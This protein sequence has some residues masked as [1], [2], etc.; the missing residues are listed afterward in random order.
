M[1]DLRGYLHRMRAFR[2]APAMPNLTSYLSSLSSHGVRSRAPRKLRKRHVRGE[3]RAV[4]DETIG[5]FH[6]V[7]WVAEQIYGEEGRSL[8]RRGILRGLVRYGPRTVPQL[9]LARSVTRQHTQEVVD[10]L[11]AEGLVELVPNPAHARSRLV[12][13][14]ARGAAI[15]ARMDDTDARVLIAI[16]DGLSTRDLAITVRTLRAVREA[17]EDEA[18]WRA[19]L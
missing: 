13:A 17:F 9:A 1:F 4:V 14:T 5:L 2:E 11:L 19:A 16:G 3:L 10:S 15:V 8:P 12:R 7:R 6:R 18:R